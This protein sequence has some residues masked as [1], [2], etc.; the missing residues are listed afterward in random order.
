M[1]K[2]TETKKTT[3]KKKLEGDTVFAAVKVTKSEYEKIKKL[4]DEAKKKGVR[5]TLKEIM[6]KAFIEG[7]K[8]AEKEIEYA[9][10]EKTKNKK[11]K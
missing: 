5:L 1:P 6:T 3:R 4:M 7:I 11:D 2:K 8:E 10:K 9:K